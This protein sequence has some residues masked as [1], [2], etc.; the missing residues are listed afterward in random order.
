M[1]GSVP[2]PSSTGEDISIVAHACLRFALGP[3][4]LGLDTHV[5]ILASVELVYRQPRWFRLRL[6]QLKLD[7]V[8]YHVPLVRL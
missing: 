8:V 1:A 7:W 3:S 2:V 6:L 5:D 4:I